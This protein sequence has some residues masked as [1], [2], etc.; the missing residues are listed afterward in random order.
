MKSSVDKF[1]DAEYP[2]KVAIPEGTNP[3]TY[4]V[5]N[6]EHTNQEEMTE[7]ISIAE[8]RKLREVMNMLTVAPMLT[9]QEFISFMVV[10]NRVL[11]RLEKEIED[12]DESK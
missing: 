11:N 7:T 5:L 4:N 8:C 9:K 2:D 10:A 12:D 1:I 3:F 6:Q